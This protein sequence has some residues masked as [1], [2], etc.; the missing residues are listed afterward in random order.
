MDH[1]E[2]SLSSDTNPLVV[3]PA[4]LS[5]DDNKGI[6]TR[7]LRLGGPSK[8]AQTEPPVTPTDNA[9][10]TI[11]KER[12]RKNRLESEGMSVVPQ[13]FSAHLHNE[14]ERKQPSSLA[15]KRKE[16]SKVTPAWKIAPSGHEQPLR[17]RRN[18]YG[19][20]PIIRSALRSKQASKENM[21]LDCR[22][23]EHGRENELEKDPIAF[24][25]RR[26]KKLRR[27]SKSKRCTAC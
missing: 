24:P 1:V 11:N 8:N 14:R 10:R 12:K 3:K 23:N 20:S 13:C 19:P 9:E 22:R 25:E 6:K 7:R 16:K 15:N 26:M 5:S 4:L 27:M 18:G 17:E 21:M 2:P